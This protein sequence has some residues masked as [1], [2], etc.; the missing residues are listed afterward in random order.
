M[1]KYRAD[2][3]FF[4]I[5]KVIWIPIVILGVWYANTG[6]GQIGELFA[7]KFYKICKIPCPG[8]GGTRAVYYLFLGQPITSIKYH[9]AVV[10]GVVSYFHFMILY[11]V[12]KNK[13]TGT[14]GKAILIEKY[15]Y[16]LIVIILLQWIMK[17]ILQFII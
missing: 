1:K 17:I 14:P 12:R 9:P 3:V 6:Y 7:C 5:G 4:Q 11:Y 13:K 2:T 15:V 16:V 10:Y 8:C